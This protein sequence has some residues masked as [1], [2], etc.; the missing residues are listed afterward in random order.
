MARESFATQTGYTRACGISLYPSL[1]TL[2]SRHLLI[3]TNVTGKTLGVSYPCRETTTTMTALFNIC[4]YMLTMGRTRPAA[5]GTQPLQLL[6]ALDERSGQYIRRNGDSSPLLDANT[7][8]SRDGQRYHW[9]ARKRRCYGSKPNR[10]D[11]SLEGS[12]HAES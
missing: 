11:L 2:N 7:D 6:E 8:L 12:G 4:W 1:F 10:C 3:M 5:L 9:R